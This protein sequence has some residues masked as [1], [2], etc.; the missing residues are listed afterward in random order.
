MLFNNLEVVD[1]WRAASFAGRYLR[2]LIKSRIYSG[3][4]FHR[5]Q[6]DSFGMVTV[7]LKTSVALLSKSRSQQQQ[8]RIALLLQTRHERFRT[9][10]AIS[11]DEI[12][13]SI[14]GGSLHQR[15]A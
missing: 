7:F 5:H 4:D 15:R 11:V 14:Y 12:T 2:A 13:R 8:Q 1:S 6:P 9:N 10:R 3:V